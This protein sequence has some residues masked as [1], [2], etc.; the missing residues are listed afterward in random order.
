MGGGDNV[1]YHIWPLRDMCTVHGVG[2]A[3]LCRTR[4]YF[5]RTGRG[6]HLIIGT[7]VAE[8]VLVRS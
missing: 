1:T 8:T 7:D 5:Q 6:F 4:G 3:K 2:E